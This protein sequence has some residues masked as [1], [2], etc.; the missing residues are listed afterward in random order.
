MPQGDVEKLF[1]GQAAEVLADS[2]AGRPY[3]GEVIFVGVTKKRSW[4]ALVYV[5][6][7]ED[8]EAVYKAVGGRGKLFTLD[9]FEPDETR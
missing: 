8:E 9:G 7:D 3:R 1:V 5:D 2:R 6:P 4:F